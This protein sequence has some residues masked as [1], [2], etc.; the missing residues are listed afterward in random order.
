MTIVVNLL[1]GPCTGKSTVAAELFAELKKKGNNVELITEYAKDL[2]YENRDTTFKDQLYILAK[3]HHKMLMYSLNNVDFLITDSPIFL[4][5][6]YNSNVYSKELIDNIIYECRCSFLNVDIFLER[7]KNLPYQTLGRHH[8]L[9][10]SLKID[11]D[12]KTEM[13]KYYSRHEEFNDP[14]YTTISISDHTVQDIIDYLKKYTY[15]S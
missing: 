3:Q 11:N 7:D 8:S 10:D 9:E 14:L 15:I 1:G 6:I 12:I 4:S 5:Y 2:V 13:Q